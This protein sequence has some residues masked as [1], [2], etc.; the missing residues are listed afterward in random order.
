MDRFDCMRYAGRLYIMYTRRYITPCLSSRFDLIPLLLLLL[1]LF[2]V[3]RQREM[4]TLPPTSVAV[5]NDRVDDAKVGRKEADHDHEQK[6]LDAGARF[7]L[8]S[9][10]PT[11]VEDDYSRAILGKQS[12]KVPGSRFLTGSLSGG[13]D[14]LLSLSLKIWLFEIRRAVPLR[15]LNE[16]LCCLFFYRDINCVQEYAQKVAACR[17]FLYLALLKFYLTSVFP[18]SFLKNDLSDTDEQRHDNIWRPSF[19]SS[20]GPLTVGDSVMKNNITATVVARNLLTPRDNKI[21]SERSEESAVQDSLALITFYSY[22]LISLVLEHYAQLGH[23]HL[24][25]RDMTHDILGT[26]QFED[27]LLASHFL[28]MC[29]YR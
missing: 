21:L 26:Y 9:K 11:T 17:N 14:I 27:P 20:N 5:D 19:L 8:K 29:T 6:Q 7:V 1:V 25:F 13:S 10:A 3:F 22:N 2:S 16:W 23:R 4:G 15:S 12:G 18:S 28:I 24:R